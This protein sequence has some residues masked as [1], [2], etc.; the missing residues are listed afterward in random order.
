M[1][2]P[3]NVNHPELEPIG[4]GIARDLQDQREH[5]QLRRH[6][7]HRTASWRSSRV[8]LKYGADTVMDLSTGGDIPQIREAILRASPI[9]VGTVPIYEAS[10]TSSDVAR[11]SRRGCSSTSSSSR[12]SRASTT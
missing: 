11:T 9:P 7:R 5:R 6:V 12:R 1:V 2:I 8:C 3:A 10:P 4:I